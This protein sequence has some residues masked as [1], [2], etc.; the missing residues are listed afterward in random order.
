MAFLE[1][2]GDAELSPGFFGSLLG[3]IIGGSICMLP[4]T[5][6]LLYFVKP[7]GLLICEDTIVFLA[8][9]PVKLRHIDIEKIVVN[10]WIRVEKSSL[11][12]TIDINGIII[13]SRKR[14]RPYCLGWDHFDQEQFTKVYCAVKVY[15]GLKRLVEEHYSGRDYN[16]AS[17]WSEKSRK[18]FSYEEIKED[19]EMINKLCPQYLGIIQ[20]ERTEVKENVKL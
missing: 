18:E 2:L 15:P 6:L 7:R 8:F 10:F 4:V 1:V 11:K 20:K 14:D 16:I 19:V 5:L 13:K 17:S 9:R 12:K 3:A